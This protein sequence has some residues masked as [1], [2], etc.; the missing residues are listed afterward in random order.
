MMSLIRRD[1]VVDVP[2]LLAWEH[3]SRVEKWTSWAK[4]ITNVEL[5]PEGDL[6]LLSKGTFLLSNGLKTVFEM[7]EMDPPRNWKWV[8]SFLWMTIHYDHQFERV[9]EQHT[10]LIWLLDGEGLGISILGKIFARIYN[11]NLDRAFPN[12]CAEIKTLQ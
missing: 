6:T 12:L 3:L 7:K 9:D 5:D 4:H 8:G 11:R 2:L 1:F 10:R